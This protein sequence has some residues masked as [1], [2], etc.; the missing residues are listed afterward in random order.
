MLGVLDYSSHN[1]N[2]GLGL[3]YAILTAIFN[4]TDFGVIMLFCVITWGFPKIRGTF[5]G[6]PIIRIVVFGGL[7][8]GPLI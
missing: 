2:T 7:C 3:G 6:V 8:W 5:L 1:E 4:Y